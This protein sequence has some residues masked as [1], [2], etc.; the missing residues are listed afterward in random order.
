MYLRNINY[1]LPGHVNCLNCFVGSLL[2]NTGQLYIYIYI[3][4]H[5]LIKERELGTT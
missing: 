3:Y 2:L 1:N 5:G 4:M